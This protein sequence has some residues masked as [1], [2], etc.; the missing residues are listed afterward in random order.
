M[1]RLIRQEPGATMH[2]L[3]GG[4]PRSS[5]EIIL[6]RDLVDNVNDPGLKVRATG[7]LA[8]QF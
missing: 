2:A 1:S 6:S 5:D 7:A 4:V 3:A 8:L